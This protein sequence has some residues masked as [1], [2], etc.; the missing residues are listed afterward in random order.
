MKKAM[1]QLDCDIAFYDASFN[2][3]ASF[4]SQSADCA[5]YKMFQSLDM[6]NRCGNNIGTIRSLNHRADDGVALVKDWESHQGLL[7]G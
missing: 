1:L 6:M 3:H 7:I 4:F 5:D 2:L